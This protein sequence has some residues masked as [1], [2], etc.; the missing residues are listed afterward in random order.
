MKYLLY[1]LMPL[2]ILLATASLAIVFS[3][4]VLLVLGDVLL[5]S[6]LTNKVTQVF[7]I[8]SIFPIK[9]YLNL[10]WSELGFVRAKTFFSQIT[11]GLGLGFMTLL[12]VFLILF[13][14][15]VNVFDPDRI[16]TLGSLIQKTAI[17]LALALLISLLEEPLFRGVLLSGL[18]IKMPVMAAILISST[19]YASLHFLKSHTVVGYQDMSIPDGFMLLGEALLNV[20][21]P[22]NFQ[23]FL[24]LL[25]VGLFLGFVRVVL[26]YSLGM[27]IGCHTAWVW[28]IKMSKSLFNVNPDS[29]YL[30]LVSSYDGVIGPLVTGWMALVMSGYW[31][32]TRYHKAH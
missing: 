6:K 17:A 3:Y 19:Y 15:E 4:G 11:M 25:M 8:I 28:Q 5:L 30:Y 32:Y 2:G 31:L 21:N 18:N 24:A 10:S 16:W 14:L 29:D 7:L 23:A 22:E 27:V 26:G 1:S 20:I 12:P 13:A 9:H